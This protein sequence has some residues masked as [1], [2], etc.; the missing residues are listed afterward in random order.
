MN[1]KL[2]FFLLFVALSFGS[3]VLELDA[4]N[5]DQTIKDN[6]LILVEFFAPWCGH[7]KR[8]EPEYEKAAADLKSHNIA[9]A[10]VNADAEHNKP[11]A[12][13]YGIKGFPTI[14]LF[15]NGVPTDYTGERSSDSIVSFMKRQAKPAV[16]ALA[17]A[18]ELEEFIKD[19]KVSIV[20]FFNSPD[21]QEYTTFAQTAESLRNN[22]G[23]GVVV[24]NAEVNKHY[25]VSAPNVVLFKKFD[26]GK[27]VLGSDN[28]NNIASFIK[29][30][31]VPLIDEI[32]PENYKLYA[33]AGIPLGY[34]FV[35]SKVEGQQDSYLE[36][37]RAVAQETKGK[38]NWVWI[39]W[40]K[41]AKHSEKLGLSG[42][43]VPCL[44]I[45]EMDIGLH[46]AFDETVEITTASVDSWTKKYLQKELEP[47]I[48]SEPIPENNDAP[49]KVL[50]AKTF[51]QIVNDPTK[52]VLVEFY[53]PWCGH[54]KKLA[55]IYDELA[56]QFT[57]APSIVI[58]KIDATANDID[59]RLGI[60]GFPT[61]KFFP[62]SN[63]TPIEY[64][65]DR[66]QSDLATFI[67]THASGKIDAGAN[68][69][70]L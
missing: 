70:E 22:F 15:R 12:N 29:T 33:E 27:N 10:K 1:S 40:N 55:P 63:K 5:F 14:K 48:K 31:S 34:L 19:D 30:S 7:C 59:P 24:G 16:T 17:S 18:E 25:D 8:L 49:V 6:S 65:G 3:D 57:N 53:A 62:A 43:V 50:V 61:L 69:D 21:G 52:D 46:Y 36:K 54:C 51:D 66:S 56:S 42:N 60:R 32:G 68:K 37:I 9:I 47:T 28:F 58:A 44:A 20:G 39:D 64:N 2:V 35:D 4:E 23:F 38:M 13:T 26:E 11:L 41:F 67:T 45:E